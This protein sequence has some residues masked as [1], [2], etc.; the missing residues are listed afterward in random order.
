MARGLL[1]FDSF[2]SFV[3]GSYNSAASE[4]DFWGRLQ[5]TPSVADVRC[6]LS[7]IQD[8]TGLDHRRYAV[9]DDGH[10][11]PPVHIQDPSTYFAKS[12]PV[13]APS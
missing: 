5:A 3:Q 13:V 7:F 6:Y 10:H 2:S 9:H 12:S 11:T 8:T 1:P 4:D